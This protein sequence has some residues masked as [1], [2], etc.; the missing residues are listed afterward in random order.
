MRTI[1][2]LKDA[3][4]IKVMPWMGSS[5]CLGL[6]GDELSVFAALFERRY[7]DSEDSARIDAAWLCSYLGC[8]PVTVHK[9]L[10][11]LLKKGYVTINLQGGDFLDAF[12]IDEGCVVA[13]ACTD[14]EL[15][16][17]EY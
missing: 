6:K 4:H 17:G 8:E 2:D 14:E 3:P 12:A 1:N 13:R 7:G 5:D 16:S 11:D 15:I 10:S 9:I